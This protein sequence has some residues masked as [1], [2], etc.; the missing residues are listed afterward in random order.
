MDNIATTEVKITCMTLTERIP[1]LSIDLKKRM[2]EETRT[3]EETGP[4]FDRKS[5]VNKSN[6]NE[7]SNKRK[8]SNDHSTLDDH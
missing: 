6:S 8:H 7:S 2:M 5:L 1:I 3:L 4:R